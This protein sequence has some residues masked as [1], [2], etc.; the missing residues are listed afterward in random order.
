MTLEERVAKNIA[1]LVEGGTIEEYLGEA[2]AIIEMVRAE[3]HDAFSCEYHGEQ[4]EPFV[5]KAE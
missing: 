1:D 5:G 3:M 2:Q 4:Y